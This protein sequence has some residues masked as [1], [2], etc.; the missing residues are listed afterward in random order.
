ME[1]W[2]ELNDGAFPD[3][4]PKSVYKHNSCGGVVGGAFPYCP[5]CGKKITHIKLLDVGYEEYSKSFF[6]SR[7]FICE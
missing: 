5:Y 7:G 1:E 2:I 4:F 6:E 3:G